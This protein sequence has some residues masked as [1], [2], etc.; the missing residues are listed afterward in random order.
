MRV[1]INGKAPVHPDSGKREIAHRS[2]G[3][4]LEGEYRENRSVQKREDPIAKLGCQ[5]MVASKALSFVEQSPLIGKN[6]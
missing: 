2:A 3:M 5:S 1:G 6:R 4:R